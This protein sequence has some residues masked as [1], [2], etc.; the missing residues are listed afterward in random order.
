MSKKQEAAVSS[1]QLIVSKSATVPEVAEFLNVS[2]QTIRYLV[3]SR[4]I[5]FFRLGKRTIRFNMERLDHWRKEREG[6]EHGTVYQA[7]K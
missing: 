3:K 7:A 4:Q 2:P 1:N 5:P 6:A